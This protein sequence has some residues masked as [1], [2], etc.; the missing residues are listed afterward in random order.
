MNARSMDGI[1]CVDKPPKTSSQQAVTRVKRA[2]GVGKAGHAG[3]LDPDAT[4]VLLV[5]LGRATR[6]FDALQAH[7]KEYIASVTLGESTDTYDASGRVTMR[8]EVPDFSRAE[9]E[10]VLDRFR[11]EIEQVPPMFSAL[12][13]QGTPL[14]ALARRGQVVERAPRRVTVHALDLLEASAAELRVRVVCSK[15]TYVRSLVHDLGQALAC[16]AHLAALVRTRS[17]PFRL[18]DAVPLVEVETHPRDAARRIVPL[19]RFLQN[20]PEAEHR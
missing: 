18:D 7:D 17:G 8:S 4:G 3:T 19:E 1:L 15:G 11:G 13:R 2:L 10:A 5:C 20:P 14:Y 9:L 16:G 12:K 6:L